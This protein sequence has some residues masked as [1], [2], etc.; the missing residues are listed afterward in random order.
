M[1]NIVFSV[2]AVAFCT[3]ALF[4]LVVLAN[5]ST[6]PC[7]FTKVPNVSG[8]MGCDDGW[9]GGAVL[10][11]PGCEECANENEVVCYPGTAGQFT[12]RLVKVARCTN[13]GQCGIDYSAS[14]GHAPTGCLVNCT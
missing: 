2:V 13:H 9:C 10:F 3:I 1:K 8:T 14:P 7:A 5:T 4:S 11:D 12:L 6:G